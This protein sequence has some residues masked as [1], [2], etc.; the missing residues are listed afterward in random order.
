[1]AVGAGANLPDP[2]PRRPDVDHPTVLFVGRDW[3][4][5]GGPLLLEA[6]RRVRQEIPEARLVVVG[7]RPPLGH[8]PGIEVVG[9][10]DRRD[11]EDDLHLRRLYASATCLALLSRFDAFPNVV[12]EA[13]LSGLAV[14]STAEGSR[15]E[16]VV[17]GRTGL[18]V[19]ERRVEPVAEALATLLG[20]PACADAMGR[21][22]IARTSQRFTWAAV[23]HRVAAA[24]RLPC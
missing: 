19:A 11:P 13:G 16:A 9:A 3:E 21:M 4:Q 2:L 5:K 10:L 1:V 14:V 8:E 7:C 22:A 18:L 24:L 20:D 15:P 23:G 6:F 17:D 12:L